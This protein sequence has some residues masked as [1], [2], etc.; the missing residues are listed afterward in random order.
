[1][2]PNNKVVIRP[3]KY[4][5]KNLI[6]IDG[7][8]RAGKFL[9]ANI[10]NG[11]ENTEPTQYYESLEQ[12][13]YLE[14]FGFINKKIAQEMLHCEIDI[15]CHKMLIG[16]NFN[17]R[18]LDKSYIFNHPYHKKYLKRCEIK[19]KDTA[20]NKF[21]QKNPHS[22][23]ITHGIMPYMDLYLD[24]FPKIKIINIQRSPLD[25][26]YSHYRQHLSY[27]KKFKKDHIYLAVLLKNKNISIP[28]Y[29]SISYKK[30]QNPTK[31]INEIILS[32][33]NLFLDSQSTYNKLSINNKRK[34]L[35]IHYEDLISDPKK[36]IN[37]MSLFL[38]RKTL[39]KMKEILK[40][41]KLPNKNY[42][43]SHDNKIKEIKA[44]ATK[45]HFNRLLKLDK[46]YYLN[47]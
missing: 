42:N 35:L 1:M 16:R 28:Q 21:Y 31:L 38:K 11:L 44:I 12:I 6:L 41:E 23:F 19:D 18:K 47:K 27:R 25:L 43:S 40:K 46:E 39:P 34:I 3:R 33:E 20:L 8:T 37:N 36:A 10:L 14:K 9:L 24:T 32:I 17:Y 30:T 22:P 45:K 29:T 2:N 7:I 26:V 4:L 13:P 15:H 5:V